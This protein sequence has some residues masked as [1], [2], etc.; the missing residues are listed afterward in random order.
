MTALES[1]VTY[2]LR[3]G[4]SAQAPLMPRGLIETPATGSDEETCRALNA[5]FLVLLAGDT[6]PNATLARDRLA[7]AAP[8]WGDLARFYLDGTRTIA[9]EVDRRER[10]DPSFRARGEAVARSLADEATDRRTTSEAIWSVLFPEGTGLRGRTE[11]CVADLRQRRTVNVRELNPEPIRHPAAEILFTSN[12]LLTTPLGT[13]DLSAFDRPFQD[14]LAAAAREP[15]RSWYDH[16][17][18]IGVAADSN[19]IIYGLRHLDEAVGDE[20][21]RHPETSGRV[22]CVLSVSVTHTG[23]RALA[24]PYLGQVLAECPALDHLD[25]FAFTEADAEALVRRVLLPIVERCCPREHAADL[26]SVVGVDGRYGR[27]YSFLKAIAAFWHVLIDPV[28]RATFKIDLDQVFPQR[29]LVD[30]TGRSAFEHLQTALWGATG[31]DSRGRPVVLGMVAGSLVNQRDIHKGLFTPDVTYPQGDLAPDEFAFFSRLPQALSTEAEMA[32]RDSLVTGRD[33]A[34]TCL[35]RI[36]VTGGT[37]GILVS[38][39]RQFRP[40]TPSFIG[41]AEDQAYIL[42]TLGGPVRLGYVHAS[43]LVMRHDK[44]GFAQEAIAA[45]KVGK[46][47]GDYERIL[48]FSAY[49]RALDPEVDE[50]KKLVDPFTGCF[51][52][53]LPA[54]VVLLRFALRVADLFA[55][56]RTDEAMAFVQTG[57]DRLR[58]AL[59]FTA[60]SPSALEQ[61]YEH[62]RL[63]W[64]LYYDSLTAV[65]HALQT[66]ETWARSLRDEARAIV[67]GCRVT[68]SARAG[69]RGEGGEGGVGTNKKPEVS[70]TTNL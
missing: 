69:G 68:R 59:D 56:E 53:Q 28:I 39:L 45:A 38:A 42:S 60:G 6:H 34:R 2:L 57:V 20:C 64:Q 23:L 9:A 21:R 54:T 19:E 67:A 13:A 7:A 30:Q 66:G 63:G 41:R 4:S 62:E 12:V 44:E 18:P 52:S 51:I 46:E 22:T 48:M 16:P 50:I 11:D 8:E 27:H 15:Q 5:A 55:R 25:V 3:A 43:G 40:F 58:S 36:H 65:E 35:E 14:Q 24:R 32:V 31:E 61:A 70:E 37:N 49:A 26:L 33:G 1:I 47:I 10:Q 29:E 17:I